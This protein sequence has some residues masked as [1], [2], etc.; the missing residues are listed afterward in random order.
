MDVQNALLL[1]GLIVIVL[2]WAGVPQLFPKFRIPKG[3]HLDPNARIVDITTNRVG[4]RKNRS[5]K[6]VVTFSD[7]TKYYTH[8]SDGEYHFGYTRLTVNAEV[9]ETIKKKAQLAH[10]KKCGGL[11]SNKGNIEDSVAQNATLHEENTRLNNLDTSISLCGNCG[12]R[13]SPDAL[14]CEKCGEKVSQERAQYCRFCGQLLEDDA[15]FCSS[16]GHKL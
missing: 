4:S 6:T 3:A 14:F 9:R 16:C 5:L 11:V 1:I 7:G 15:L 13:I 8:Y 12:A 2:L 10:D